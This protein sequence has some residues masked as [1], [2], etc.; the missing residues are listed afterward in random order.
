M[1]SRADGF[2]L[3]DDTYYHHI[4]H[5]GSTWV[6]QS[7][8]TSQVGPRTKPPKSP[9][10]GQP[11]NPRLTSSSML[12]GK[13]R[14]RWASFTKPC[15]QQRRRDPYAAWHVENISNITAPNQLPILESGG[16]EKVDDALNLAIVFHQR[17]KYYKNKLTGMRCHGLGSTL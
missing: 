8:C 2:V 11:G 7:N 16:I 12:S 6:D 17:N 13:M 10:L 1:P 9:F 14:E 3:E 4:M 5:D 15:E